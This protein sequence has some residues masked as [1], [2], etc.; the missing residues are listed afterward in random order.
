MIYSINNGFIKLDVDNHGAEAIRL[1]FHDLNLLRTKDDV[2]GRTS[3]ILWPIVGNLKDKYTII[4]GKTY[5]MKNHGFLRDRDWEVVKHDN[6]RLVLVNYYDDET[7]K[8]FPFK[9]K[10]QM[11]YVS[12]KE[13]LK[14][15]IRIKNIDEVDF[16]YNIG[17]HPGFRCPL[18]DGEQFEDYRIVFKNKETFDAPSYKKG[19]WDF[20]KPAFIFKNAKEIKLDYKY[21]QIDALVIKNIKSKEVSLLN[22]DNHGIVFRF[23]GFNTLAFWTIPNNQYI[24]FEPWNGYDDLIDSDHEFVKKDDLIYIKP[25]EEKEVSYEISMK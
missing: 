7:L 2:W 15:I 12:N 6:N 4:N 13:S 23:N 20:N 21:F 9:Y 22:K 17:A 11:E 18:F 3:P 25:N 5:E 24:C 8:R 14:V 10:A 1:F 16:C 19:L